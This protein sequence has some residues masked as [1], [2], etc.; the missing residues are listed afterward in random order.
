MQP[1][2]EDRARRRRGLA[3]IPLHDDG[4]AHENLADVAVARVVAR[5]RR[6]P[7]LVGI[8]GLARRAGPAPLGSSRVM[9]V[10]TISDSRVHE[11]FQR[12]CWRMNWW[13]VAGTIVC[14]TAS[15]W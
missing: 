5:R 9:N 14:E 1:T 7:Q 12:S 2:V 11:R 13:N 3:R 6:D 8:E 4:P 10:D 15:E